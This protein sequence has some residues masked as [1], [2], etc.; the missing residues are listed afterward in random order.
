MALV[1]GASPGI[2][3]SRL[4]HRRFGLGAVLIIAEVALSLVVLAGAG[5]FARS[6]AN[7]TGQQFGF[8]QEGVLVVNMDTSHAG[9]NYSQLGPLYRQLYSRLNSLPGVK[10]ASFSKSR[11]WSR[12]R[13]T[14]VL[15]KS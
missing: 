8:D 7:L 11:A 13:S 9:Y 1:K 5:T 10:S 3:G 15:V 4:S 6:L 14:T 2:K 12:M